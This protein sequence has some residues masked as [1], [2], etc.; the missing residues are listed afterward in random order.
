MRLLIYETTHHETLPGI[1]DLA[2][3]YFE[4]VDVYLK[5][6]TYQ[7][8]CGGVKPEDKWTSASFIRQ[9]GNESNQDFIRTVVG[10]LKNNNY[11]HFHIS[12][13]DNNLLYFA[14][15]LY[16]QKKVHVSLSVQAINEYCAFRYNSFRDI[17]ESIAKL[18]FHKKIRHYRVFFPLMKEVLSKHLANSTVQFI[19]SRFFQETQ[20]HPDKTN[21]YF[22]IV[23]PGSVDPNR[24]DYH[25]AL[26]FLKKSLPSLTKERP[27][28]VTILGSNKTEY[29]VKFLSELEV[30]ASPACRIKY[31]KEYVAQT[32]YENELA[33]ADLIWSPVRI[34]TV[35][36]RGTSEIYGTS[37]ATGL[38]ADLLF[39]ATPA[40]LPEGFKIPEH[41]EDAIFLYDSEEKLTELLLKFIHE[42]TVTNKNKISESLSFFVKN[43]F[44]SSFERLMNISP[45]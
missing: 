23:I 21:N 35:G 6:S 28:E 4:K 20:V 19:P 44:R 12:T 31:Y 30:L 2:E 3:I 25:F 42:G 14:S 37:T 5:E 34:R 7:N 40:L 15:H 41:Y 13:L 39:C 43:N 45:K 22:K 29:T 8:I 36:I 9:S 38:M 33:A 32:E 11:S 16:N 18:Y 17:T 27:I 1:L 26:S 10:A 24:R